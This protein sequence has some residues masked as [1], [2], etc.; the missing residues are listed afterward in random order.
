MEDTQN[1][2]QNPAPSEKMFTQAEVDEIV[3]KR[4]VRERKSQ[5]NAIESAVNAALEKKEEETRIANLQGEEKLKAEYEAKI[6]KSDKARTEL[7]AQLAESRRAVA[8]LHARADLAAQGLPESFAESVI[9][10]SDEETAVKIADLARA[11]NSAV[12]AKVTENLHR[13]APPTGGQQANKDD[14]AG[15]ELDRLM[16]IR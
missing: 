14:D 12:D 13:G 8:V 1:P 15:A 3:E 6:A 7:E 5:A 9:G 2:E 16:G 4:L 10:A 11:F